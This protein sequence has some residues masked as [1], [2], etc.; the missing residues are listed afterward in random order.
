MFTTHESSLSHTE[1]KVKRMVKG[2][3]TIGSQLCSQ[4]LHVQKTRTAG[5]QCQ[6]RP[7]HYLGRK[8]IAFQGHT[9]LDSNISNN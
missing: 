4:T 9:E 6:L 8:G 1:A 3:P 2:R 7:V 5:F